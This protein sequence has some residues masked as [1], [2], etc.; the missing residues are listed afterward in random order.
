MKIEEFERLRRQQIRACVAKALAK[1]EELSISDV[2][3]LQKLL[4]SAVDESLPRRPSLAELK[5]QQ[6]C[7][8]G[9]AGRRT[10][11][12]LDDK[13]NF[14]KANLAAVDSLLDQLTTEDVM[15]RPGLES[16]RR[17]LLASIDG[18]DADAAPD[19]PDYQTTDMG[20]VKWGPLPK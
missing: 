1:D 17:E 14:L 15:S 20:W 3:T 8:W 11:P 2:D 13:R 18:L 9:P 16:H 10:S 4:A 12:K 7:V 5:A 6:R 19:R